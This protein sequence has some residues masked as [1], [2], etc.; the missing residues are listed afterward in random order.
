VTVL[1]SPAVAD[2]LGMASLLE[3]RNTGSDI[4]EHAI[5]AS[6]DPGLKLAGERTD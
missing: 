1:H 6:L 3:A 2:A 4:R 5:F